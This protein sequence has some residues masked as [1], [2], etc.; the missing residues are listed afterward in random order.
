MVKDGLDQGMN[1]DLPSALPGMMLQ[2]PVAP[3][4]TVLSGMTAKNGMDI[5][6]KLDTAHRLA[7]FVAS[8]LL[9]NPLERQVVLESLDIKTRLVNV[10]HFLSME[11]ERNNMGPEGY[12]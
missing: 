11:I 4:D 5:L 1:G 3:P 8:T 6:K 9:R 2:S 7:D 12:S 10:S